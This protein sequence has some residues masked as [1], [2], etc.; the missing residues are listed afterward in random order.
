MAAVVYTSLWRPPPEEVQWMSQSHKDKFRLGGSYL[1]CLL[2]GMSGAA[3]FSTL[4]SRAQDAAPAAGG[5]TQAHS[6]WS[7]STA[8]FDNSFEAE[9]YVGNGYIGLFPLPGWAIWESLH[10]SRLADW[11]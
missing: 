5:Q 10:Q 2:L 4:L 1:I 9:P 3:S 6:V 7:L 8:R 11:H